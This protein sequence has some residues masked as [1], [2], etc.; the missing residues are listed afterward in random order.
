MAAVPEVASAATKMAARRGGSHVMPRS[1]WLPGHWSID[2]LNMAAEKGGKKQGP[3]GASTRL[4]AYHADTDSA[5][6]RFSAAFPGVPTRAVRSAAPGPGASRAGELVGASRQWRRRLSFLKSC[7]GR[8]LGCGGSPTRPV[9]SPAAA[10]PP[11]PSP[12]RP[13]EM[14]ENTIPSG[15]NS[16]PGCL[17]LSPARR[18]AA[19]RSRER[20]AGGGS[21]CVRREDCG[22]LGRIFG[23]EK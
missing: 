21:C 15:P 1:R 6:E 17:S 13:G 16:R 20:P 14:E 3:S 7:R 8:H 11:L 9:P 22:A 4:P 12:P 5:P 10:S 18:G 19:A 2:L 23:I